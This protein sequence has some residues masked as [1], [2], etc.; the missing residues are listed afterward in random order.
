MSKKSSLI[1]KWNHF[2]FESVDSIRLDTFRVCIGVTFFIYML[3]WWQYAPEWLTE[4]GFHFSSEASY[5]FAPFVLPPLP[6]DWLPIFGLILFGSI[7]A[8]IFGWHIRWAALV[9]FASLFYICRADHITAFTINKLFLLCLLV[10]AAAPEG[11]YWRLGRRQGKKQS[12]WPVR[13]LQITLVIQYGTAGFCKVVH[14]D[15]LDTPYVLW[16][17][18]QGLYCTDIGAWMLENLPKWTWGGFQYSALGFEL[19]AP[20]LFIYKPLRK[21]GFVWGFGF[22]MM[23]AAT[24]HL[25]IYFSLQMLV[26]YLLFFKEETLLKLRKRVIA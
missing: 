4:K 3:G 12:V 15:W 7:L 17:Q 24:M 19:L 6:I 13:V 8:L 10:L 22:Q 11:K 5:W 23:I 1:Q 16:S 25:L 21:V 18:I 9:G 2:W 26:F 20:L 14:G